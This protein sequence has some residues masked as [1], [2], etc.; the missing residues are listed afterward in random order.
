M[1]AHYYI[2]ERVMAVISTLPV[3]LVLAGCEG[4]SIGEK[5]SAPSNH[6]SPLEIAAVERQHPS[7][8]VGVNLPPVYDWA[9][10]PAAQELGATANSF[11]I[12]SNVNSATPDAAPR[13]EEI[14]L[15]DY[16]FAKYGSSEERTRLL[17]RWDA[18]IGSLPQ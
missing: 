3:A 15:I 18:E 4:Q 11:Q 16:D 13:L 10:T 14:K 12:P 9:L 1:A 5:P 8:S 6:P 2:I 7:L 17:A